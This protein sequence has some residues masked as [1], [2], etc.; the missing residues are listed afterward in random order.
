MEH[1][2]KS[3]A[4]RMAHI[5][6]EQAITLL[7]LWGWEPVEFALNGRIEVILLQRGELRSYSADA[8]GRWHIWP[9]DPE[10]LWQWQPCEWARFSTWKLKGCIKLVEEGHG[11]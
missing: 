9:A 10:S 3:R 11:K 6:R 7:A 5:M 1:D 2:P 4:E 8:G